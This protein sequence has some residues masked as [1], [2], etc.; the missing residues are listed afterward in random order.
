MENNG[1]ISATDLTMI[2]TATIAGT[3]A[4]AL[5]IKQDYRQYPS[6]PNGYLIHFVTGALAATLGAF[7]VPTLMSKNFVAVTFLSLAIQQFREVRKTERESLRDLEGTEFT[8]RGDSYMDGIA[9]TFEARNYFALLVAF[10]T[11]VTMQLLNLPVWI[12]VAAGSLAGL[13][14]FVFLRRF[15]KGKQV[16]DI[17]T[18]SQGKIEIKGSELYVDGLLVTN[19]AGE[20]EAKKFFLEEGIAAVIH[21]REP[22]LRIVLEHFGQRQAMLFEAARAIGKKRYSFQNLMEGKVIIALV[23]IVHNFEL[24]KET[25]LNTPLLES[26]KKTHRLMN[27]NVTGGKTK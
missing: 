20:E 8:I 5:T 6:H 7:I 3:L 16:K 26:V 10:I 2:V 4:R 19:A 22:H 12:E 15:T 13:L 27:V 25:V 1:I 18:V 17:A 24:M 9:K 23:P 21:P 14:L 11:S